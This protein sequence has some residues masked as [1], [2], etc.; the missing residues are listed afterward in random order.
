[1]EGGL[2]ERRGENVVNK[3]ACV[4]LQELYICCRNVF[5]GRPSGCPPPPYDV[6]AV[7]R[8]LDSMKLEDLG[9]SSDLQLS[10]PGCSV[11][12]K[13][14]VLSTTIYK[15]H[16]FSLVLFFLPQS[17]VIPLHN[18]P[19]MTVFSKLLQGTMHIKSYDWV[20]CV[21][22]KESKKPSKLRLAKLIAD[23]DFTAPCSPSVL[24]PTSG[25][26]IHCFTAITPCMVLDVL[27]PPYSKEDGR[28]GSYYRDFP[29]NPISDG[30]VVKVEE[31]ESYGWL[32]EIEMPEES[33]MGGIEYLGPQIIE[34]A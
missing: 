5:R 21:D 16:E 27:G 32:E 29:Y 23:G 31:G 20:D 34:T 15:S 13:P 26:N 11:N 8:I 10:N 6:Q 1:M 28:D 14:R 3:V 4:V 18:H 9:L 12:G 17:A 7:C 24:Y 19:Q 33:Q 2:V 22:M 25:G 30:E